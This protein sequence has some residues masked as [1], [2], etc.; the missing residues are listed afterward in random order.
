ML[1]TLINLS[2]L[3]DDAA[4]LRVA[5]AGTH[6]L[7]PRRT[8]GPAVA[9]HVIPAAGVLPSLLHTVTLGS[10]KLLYSAGVV[11]LQLAGD[12]RWTIDVDRFAGTPVLKVIKESDAAY[13]ITLSGAR[14]PGTEI[15]ADLDARI[16]R[17][18]LTWMIELQ[19]VWG[20]FHAQA[21][22]LVGFLDGS[23]K[24]ASA[25][26]L[27]GARLCPLSGPAEVVAGGLGG[28]V[29]NPSWLILVTGPS[30]VK[31][32]GY[33]EELR[34][35]LLAVGLV[36]A[37]AAS[38]MLAPPS[39]RSA[40]VV[41][42]GVPFDLDFWA[43][44][45]GGFDFTSGATPFRWLV[46]DVGEEPDGAAKRAIL[47]TGVMETRVNFGPAADVIAI[48][49]DR[50]RVALNMPVFIAIYDGTGAMLGRGLLAIPMD[51][52]AG[53]H[54]PRLSVLAGRPRDFGAF[55]LGQIGDKFG[56]QCE[57]QWLAHAARPGRVV[58]DPSAPPSLTRLR[59]VHGE[60]AAAPPADVGE[61]RV[62]LAEGS[63]LTSPAGITLEVVRPADLM[64]LSFGLLG[65]RLRC[66]GERGE[67]VRVGGAQARL[68]V[69]FPPQSIGEEAFQEG[70]NDDPLVSV[71]PPPVRAL[72]AEPS[73]LVFTIDGNEPLDF[74]LTTLLDWQDPRLSPRL[75]PAA[76]STR[77]G[78]QPPTIRVP[79]ADETAIEAPWHVVI[80]PDEA[81]V[82][83]HESEVA[84]HAGRAELWH[85]RLDRGVARAGGSTGGGAS[86]GPIVVEPARPGRVV[87]PRIPGVRVTT[88]TTTPTTTRTTTPTTT[89]TTTPTTTR[90]TIG[91]TPTVR[92]VNVV[93]A[94][95]RL[96]P[97]VPL[98]PQGVLRR[99]LRPGIRAIWTP[100]YPTPP[101]SPM[102]MSLNGDDRRDLVYQTV[103]SDPARA[104]L[105]LLSSL[106][107]WLDLEALWR[108][109]S[110]PLLSWDHRATMGRDHFV[111]VV[112][113]G[114]IFPF[115]HRALK[116][117]VTER[118]LQQQPIGRLAAYLRKRTFVV[119][120][121]PELTY[122]PGDAARYPH[123]GREVALE[124]VRIV[125]RRT[126]NLDAVGPASQISGPW[127]PES[128]FW[129]RVGGADLKLTIVGTDR[130]GQ[131]V[132]LCA[133]AAFIAQPSPLDPPGRMLVMANAAIA[134]M[135]AT[136]ARNTHD[137]GGQALAF[138][139][140]A[141]ARDTTF[142]A[143]SVT[144]SATGAAWQPGDAHRPFFPWT[145]AATI[146]APTLRHF[147]GGPGPHAVTYHARY[148]S[149]GF[150]GQSDV[151][152][153]LASPPE[154]AFGGGNS[155]DRVGGLITPNL[156]VGGLSRK[157]GLVGEGLSSLDSGKFDPATYFGGIADAKLLGGITLAAI[158]GKPPLSAGQTPHWVEEE[159]GGVRRYRLAWSTTDFVESGFFKR[160]GATSLT[161]EAVA[162]VA[163]DGAVAATTSATLTKFGIEL[164]E[165]IG[166]DF[167]SLAF[168]ARPGQKPDVDV[169]ISD[170]RLLGAL[171]FV[172]RLKD[173][174][175]LANFNDPPAIDVSASGITVSYTLAIP[176]ITI[177]VFSLQNLR[178]SAGLTLPF[179]GTPLRARFAFSSRTDPFT[180]TVMIFGGG[181]FFALGVG[182]DGV[183][184]VEVLL[185]FG[186]NW[187]LDFGVASGG[188]HA[189]A[190][191][192]IRHEEPATTALTGYVRAGGGIS[193]LGIVSVS[194]ELYIGLTYQKTGDSSVAWG[195]A[196]LTVEVEV[197]FFSVGFSVTVR[198]EFS[199]SSVSPTFAD[200]LSE[201]EWA[202]YAAAFA[203]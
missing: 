66:Q 65:L 44:G 91:A 1:E 124:T 50:F 17:V 27:G 135:A 47:A 142:E 169:D 195:E 149:S 199:G 159:A 203:A 200:A 123:Q 112:R 89:R 16:F 82:W 154:L 164:F 155:A 4:R 15:P 137:L 70:E 174:L 188:I 83:S 61:L 122:L 147:G 127:S 3:S 92:R 10:V 140:S 62:G 185:E 11:R 95:R 98:I 72:I 76:L 58:A 37:D 168:I 96:V 42:A 133:P 6:L 151:F 167:Q 46:L 157:L 57:L 134:S 150:D 138:A 144:L 85:T 119:I 184:S 103:N 113:R 121:E 100:G 191:I 28:A 84:E 146:V 94:V 9:W 189:M 177:G 102:T 41:G 53:L 114:F 193:V 162:E 136:T 52:R 197:L 8:G 33:G 93:E 35:D 55:V 105:L 126:P 180:I 90:T 141:A 161:L 181:G 128:A 26:A 132:D 22:E 23:A 145:A 152:L 111:R 196:S 116:I 86:P 97:R 143:A 74:D 173:F 5:E 7:L 163:T 108:D 78:A 192:Y 183:E 201:A 45:A 2:A 87:T 176:A 179:D 64:V 101:A 31:L 187:A 148:L 186:G 165:V 156:K 117:D 14:F 130:A 139:P 107:A 99:D 68:A 34:R 170:V 160:R 43:D 81:G 60:L 182:L 29:F 13:R 38:V 109:E 25:V 51:R 202:E 158:L 118:K 125:D 24:A 67:I 110:L 79:A 49:G 129:L 190:G 115:G 30:I 20:G 104:D 120:L 194:I 73:R 12:D 18:G 19:I 63:R 131:R 178:L 39:R 48:D 175:D 40:L 171:S 106:G 54:T 56:I 166:V 75:A 172:N 77:S 71:H 88:P 198:R 59:I 36:A 80:S 21:I 153:A 32:R 69:R